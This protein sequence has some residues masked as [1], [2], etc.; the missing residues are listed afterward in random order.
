MLLIAVD[1]LEASVQYEAVSDGKVVIK[2]WYDNL[3]DRH[4]YLCSLPAGGKFSPKKKGNKKGRKKERVK[5]MKE[6][7][8]AR[9]NEK[10]S[11]I[12]N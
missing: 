1:V 2:G 7:K 12:Y 11:N 3:C 8:E 9:K 6:I 5:A 4:P 10:N